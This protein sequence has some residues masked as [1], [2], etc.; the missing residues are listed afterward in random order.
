[1]RGIEQEHRLCRQMQKMLVE[2]DEDIAGD[3]V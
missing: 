2:Q 1:M 3:V